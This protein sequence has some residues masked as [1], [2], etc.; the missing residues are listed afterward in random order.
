MSDEI[1]SHRILLASAKSRWCQSWR[2]RLARVTSLP[3]RARGLLLCQHLL[4]Q[5]SCTS[6]SRPACNISNRCLTGRPCLLLQCRSGAR[7][8][9]LP[10]VQARPLAEVRPRGCGASPQMVVHPRAIHSP[11]RLGFTSRLQISLLVKG[12]V[13]GFRLQC[14]ALVIKSC[15]KIGYGIR[16]ASPS[17]VKVHRLQR[18][19][20]SIQARWTRST[21]SQQPSAIRMPTPHPTRH[22]MRGLPP[23]RLRTPGS[24]RDRGAS[25]T[26][27]SS[28][29]ARIPRSFTGLTAYAAVWPLVRALRRLSVSRWPLC[30]ASPRH[31]SW[32]TDQIFRLPGRLQAWLDPFL[33]FSLSLTRSAH[34]FAAQRTLRARYSRQKCQTLGLGT[35]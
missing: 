19:S 16:E 32:P 26:L 25:L 1:R 11:R 15:R 24:P 33:T 10:L 9:D 21:C 4:Q 12:G 22:R 14:S 3:S 28:I 8:A 23:S 7:S 27:S 18:A 13:G 35:R 31:G 34:Q 6:T 17:R 2:P 29:P 30:Q 5:G 20:V